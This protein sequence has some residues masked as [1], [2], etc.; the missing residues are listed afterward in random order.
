VEGLKDLIDNFLGNIKIPI[1]QCTVRKLGRHNKWIACKM[2]LTA[3]IREYEMDQ[4]IL[5][6]GSD[7][8]VPPKK[9]WERMGRP[10][11]QWPPIHLCMAN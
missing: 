9:T 5:D 7:V 8:N 3:Q 11:L 4:T 2:R 6:L 1:E 10:E